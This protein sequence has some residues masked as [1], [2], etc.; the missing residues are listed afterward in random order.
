MSQRT[1]QIYFWLAVPCS[2]LL[3]VMKWQQFQSWLREE[4]VLLRQEASSGHADR[5]D[6]TVSFGWENFNLKT[7]FSSFKV[8]EILTSLKVCGFSFRLYLQQG[9]IVQILNS[10]CSREH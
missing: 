4:V 2:E 5:A 8:R 10:G 7:N 9:E 6:S 3:L 1:P